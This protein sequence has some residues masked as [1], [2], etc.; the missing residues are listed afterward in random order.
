MCVAYRS[1]ARPIREAYPL[2]RLDA[3]MDQIAT[4]F[5]QIAVT[6]VG[7]DS[8]SILRYEPAKD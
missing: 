7:V 4:R 3:P 6:A 8:A 1:G 5:L 2:S